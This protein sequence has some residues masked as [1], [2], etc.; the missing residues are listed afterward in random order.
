VERVSSAEGRLP[1]GPILPPYERDA[2]SIGGDNTSV[3]VRGPRVP[4]LPAGMKNS[5][6]PEARPPLR[7]ASNSLQPRQT[8]EGSGVYQGVYDDEA[9][10]LRKGRYNFESIYS[11]GSARGEH[12]ADPQQGQQRQHTRGDDVFQSV[13]SGAVDDFEEGSTSSQPYGLVVDGAGIVGGSSSQPYGLKLTSRAGN[14]GGYE[15]QWRDDGNGGRGV[16]PPRGVVGGMN[17]SR[18]QALNAF[19]AADADDTVDGGQMG[20]RASFGM[21]SL[22]GS[23]WGDR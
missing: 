19:I 15:A 23:E 1:P 22:N 6:S 12:E 8:G 5:M 20:G 4:W 17:G 9:G 13:H 16:T 3:Y 18:R 14:G 21:S 7:D 10:A 2:S 11:R